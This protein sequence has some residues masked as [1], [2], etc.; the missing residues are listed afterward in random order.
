[1][2]SVAGHD[3]TLMSLSG[4]HTPY[5]ARDIVVIR[6]NTRHTGVSE[7]PDGEKVRQAL[8][9]AVPLVV[10]K[11]LSE[12]KN[13]PDAVRNQFTDCDAEDRGLQTFDLRITIHVVTG[14]RTA[15]LNLLGQHLGVDAASL[16]GDDQ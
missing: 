9:D 15:L 10:G 2:I 5:F 12:Y 14:I 1:M 4:A 8:E 3:G 7:V 16:L 6:D 11:A 13:V